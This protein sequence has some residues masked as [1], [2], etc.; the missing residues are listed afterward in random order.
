MA[1]KKLNQNFF[2]GGVAESNKMG[3]AGAFSFGEKLNIYDE[4]SQLTTNPAAVKDSDTTVADLVKW[5][6]SGS[7]HDTNTYFYGDAGKIYQRESD[8]TWSLLQTTTNSGGQGM[9]VYDDYLYY[10]QDEQI[11]RY[12]PLSGAVAFEDDWE[13]GLED[14]SDTNFAP[15]KAFKDGLAVGHGNKLAWYDGSAW[16]D[17]ALTLPP[18]LQIRSLEVLDEFLVI[19]T[20]RGTAITDNE[21]GYIFL[22][23]GSSTTFNFFKNIPEGG[24]NALANSRNRLLSV[25]GSSG[26]LFINYNPFEKL[27]Q[28]PKLTLAEYAEVFP[29]AMTNW[30]NL[31]CIGVSGNS[32]STTLKKGVY[33]WGSKSGRYSEVLNFAYPISTENDTGTT[34]KIGSV[35]GVGDNLFIG[36]KDD[37]TYGVDKV[38]NSGSPYA[39]SQLESLIFDDGQ[40]YSDKLAIKIKVHHLPLATGESVQIGY[41][42]N[43]ASSYTTGTANT[44]DDS[45]ET[46]LSLPP[47][48]RFREIQLEVLM[49]G[50]NSTM[51]TIT[52]LGMEYDDLKEELEY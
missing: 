50:S 41:K 25:V 34:V 24:I 46:V 28:L 16:N 21:E 11:G 52:Y 51:P 31:T 45:T 48:G 37:T 8:G 18:G 12:G 10:T 36:W 17:D 40:L 9:D 6:A 32:D 1:K 27:Q 39:T 20:W 44:T 22:W 14:T 33:L 38:T 47:A 19:G 2:Y 49:A 23:D 26:N 13:T 5:I 30:K 15:V 29:G 4:P 42:I 3:V 35:K 7:P 43:R